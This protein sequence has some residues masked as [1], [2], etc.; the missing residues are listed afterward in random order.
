MSGQHSTYEPKTGFTRWLDSRLPIIRLGWDSFIDFPTPKNLNYWWTFGGIL[1]LCL[2]IQIVTG[3][4]LAMHYNSS[5]DLAFN[6]VEHIM[7]D[8]NHGWMI[9][10]IHATGASMFFL[11]V[12]I[13]MLRGIY[14]GSYKAPRE[15]LWI[16][17]CVIYLLMMATG[18]MGYVLP[19][20][21][22]S[23]Y[24]AVVITNLLGAFPVVGHAITTWLWG[25]FAV[26][27]PTLSRFFS[28]H[29][30][31]PFMIAGVVVLHIWALHVPG[32]SNPTGVE[33]KSKED[34]IPFHP[35]YTVKDGFAMV[36]FLILF[37][38][39]VFFMPDALGHSDNYIPANPLQTPAQIVPEWYF[40]PFYAILRAIPDKLIGVLCMFGAIGVLFVLPWIDTSKVRSMRYRPAARMYFLIFILV[41]IGLGFCGAH[42]P[43]EQVIP[44][45][46]GFNLLDYNLNSFVWLSRFL[47]TY[48]FVYFLVI[49][50][51]LGFFEKSLPVP[52][53]IST[54]V[55]THSAATPKGAVADAEKKG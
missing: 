37:A 27:A 5:A 26:D 46:S 38:V 2:V 51:L 17:G 9:R 53:S 3:V 31:L 1:A 44:G 16:L 55:L 10:Y 45:V 20:G 12:Y 48:Y 14:Y 39:L 25:G 11:A 35:Y 42:E 4:I 33:V 41:A 8:V 24:G 21:Q 28:L 40:L 19:W 47:T 52:D 30:L 32:N 49:T 18:F 13:H 15:I 29:Y 6:S 50:P 54:P 43:G 34:T 36:C 23:Y 7:R 22:M